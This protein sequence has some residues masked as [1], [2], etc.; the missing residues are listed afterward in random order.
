[1]GSWTGPLPQT[2]LLRNPHL[3]PLPSDLFATEGTSQDLDAFRL[4]RLGTKL[5]HIREVGLL[6]CSTPSSFLAGDDCPPLELDT[7]PTCHESH[8]PVL[9]GRARTRRPGNHRSALHARRCRQPSPKHPEFR[10]IT[11]VAS[12]GRLAHLL[13]NCAFLSFVVPPTVP[14]RIGTIETHN[15]RDSA[16][17]RHGH[18]SSQH[19]SA[20]DVIVC[21]HTVHT[22]NVV[23]S[24]S[25]PPPP[26]PLP[27]PGRCLAYEV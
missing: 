26:Q 15:R 23:K 18:Q 10:W 11:R 17:S 6:L 16:H 9:G 19:G 5:M 8:S 3:Q 27:P 14:R 22:E 1:M 7:L 24:I 25:S 4:P 13:H 21:A 2:L 12:E 20:R